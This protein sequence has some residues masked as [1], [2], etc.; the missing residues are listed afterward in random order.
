[1]LRPICRRHRRGRVLRLRIV[2]ISN[3]DSK[4]YYSFQGLVYDEDNVL[5]GVGQWLE[6][7]HHCTDHLRTIESSM[8]P[9]LQLVV[10]CDLVV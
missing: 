9:S 3:D 1:M 8:F 10:I 6:W 5:G 4:S 2:V 7:S